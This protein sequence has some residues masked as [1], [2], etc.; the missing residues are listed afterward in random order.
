MFRLI[1]IQVFRLIGCLIPKKQ[2]TISILKAMAIPSKIITA[3]LASTVIP[4]KEIVT[5]KASYHV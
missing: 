3:S 1:P 2:R 5:L 4:S